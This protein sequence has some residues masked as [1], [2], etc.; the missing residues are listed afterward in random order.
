MRPLVLY[1]LNDP[2]SRK[3]AF[4]SPLDGPSVGRYIFLSGVK[5]RVIGILVGKI[6]LS[7]GN[8]LLQMLACRGRNLRPR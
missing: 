7:D 5:C 2:A 6:L 8:L 4:F 1:L 3:L